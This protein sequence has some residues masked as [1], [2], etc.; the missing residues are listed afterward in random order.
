MREEWLPTS[1]GVRWRFQRA[2]GVGRLELGFGSSPCV[3]QSVS[4]VQERRGSH[5]CK[6]G[7]GVDGTGGGWWMGN[8]GYQAKRENGRAH[9]LP[10]QV[11][12]NR[13]LLRRSTNSSTASSH[14]LLDEARERAWVRSSTACRACLLDPE[15]FTCVL[16]EVPEKVLRGTHAG[17][18]REAYS[19]Y[20]PSL[21]HN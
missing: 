2:S 4:H 6:L 10:S 3:T 19:P 7:S 13:A 15:A 16:C 8:G 9:V 5:D 14:A 18:E 21:L 17:P 1:A 12:C 11:S 20:H